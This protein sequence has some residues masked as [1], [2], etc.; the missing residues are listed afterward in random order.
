MPN[1]EQ[2][3]MQR[4]IAAATAK[5]RDTAERLKREAAPHT[6]PAPITGT[7]PPAPKP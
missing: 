3:A 5:D 6:R 4:L 1:D 7:V 2:D